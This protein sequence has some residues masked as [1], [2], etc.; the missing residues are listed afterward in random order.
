MFLSIYLRYH[1]DVWFVIKN[2]RLTNVFISHIFILWKR[3]FSII[4]FHIPT[5]SF[6]QLNIF[7]I[8]FANNAFVDPS[9]IL[10]FIIF[11]SF[12]FLWFFFDFLLFSNPLSIH[13]VPRCFCLILLLFLAPIVLVCTPVIPFCLVLFFFFYSSHPVQPIILPFLNII[14]PVSFPYL[15][16]PFFMVYDTMVLIK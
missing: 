5:L 14:L 9:R 4:I 8:L 10:N 13:H 16:L 2:F 11:P 3:Y 12:H 15:L 1:S 7:T 6:V